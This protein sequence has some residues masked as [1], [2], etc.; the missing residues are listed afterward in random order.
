MNVISGAEIITRNR[1]NLEVNRH[2]IVEINDFMFLNCMFT[3]FLLLKIFKKI[4]DL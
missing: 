4:H 2:L 1:E 3:K